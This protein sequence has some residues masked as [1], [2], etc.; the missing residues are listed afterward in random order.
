MLL[1]LI[2]FT[3]QP[4]LTLSSRPLTQLRQH[5][6]S[7]GASRQYLS[8]ITS[9]QFASLPKKRHEICWIIRMNFIPVMLHVPS[10]LQCS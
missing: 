6:S 2:R 10:H 8:Y 1:Q 3:L 7:A 4:S 5:V 9:T